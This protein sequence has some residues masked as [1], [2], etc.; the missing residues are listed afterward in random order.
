L[1]FENIHKSKNNNGCVIWITGLSGAGKTTLSKA[2]G[3]RLKKIG[4]PCLQLDGDIMRSILSED[5]DEKNYTYESRRKM[6]EKYSLLSLTLA[7]QGYCVITSVI[8]MFNEVYNWNKKNLPGYYEIFLDIPLFE[9]KKRD[10]K[11]IYK[12]FET[13]MITNVA[14]LDLIIQKP[15]NPDMHIK[16]SKEINIESI[17]SY[18][19]NKLSVN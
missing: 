1:K 7:S 18:V 9:L 3:N 11:G 6:A 13:G 12:K 2:L 17:T 8:G 19:I 15:K 16:D 5:K 14:G 4:I 10:P